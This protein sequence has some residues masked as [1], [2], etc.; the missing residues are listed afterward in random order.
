MSLAGWMMDRAVRWLPPRRRDWAEAMRQEFDTAAGRDRLEFAAG[1]L[2]TA[3]RERIDAMQ[4]LVTIGRWGVGL[5]TAAYGAFHLWCLWNAVQQLADGT[6]AR[7]MA[8]GGPA[9]RVDLQ[10]WII[11]L[12]PYLLGMG[13]GNALAAVCLV[14]W[15]PKGFW[16]G[17]AIVAVTAGA[18]TVHDVAHFGLGAGIIWGWQ[19]V[20]LAMMAGAALVLAWMSRRRPGGMA[21]A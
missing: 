5:V 2:W 16:L 11:W 7:H 18:L 20:P 12:L 21:A 10:D 1:C 6:F 9:Q 14:R 19:F 8:M 17:C 4:V 15:Q 3:I 13:L